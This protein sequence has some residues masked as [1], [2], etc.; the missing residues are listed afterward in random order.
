ML[1]YIIIKVLGNVEFRKMQILIVDDTVENLKLLNE[2]LDA[3]DV[4]FSRS[5]EE[6]LSLLEKEEYDLIL[7][8]IMMPGIDGYT[9]CQRL[10]NFPHHAETPVIFLTAK[11]DNESILKAFSS[12]GQDYIVKPFNT[13][14]LQ[15]RVK[16]QLLYKKY[17]N[18]LK[19][20]ITIEQEKN[21][22]K[23]LSLL[24]QSK[25]V[26]MGE[27]FSM[28]AHQWRQPLST[29]MA[30]SNGILTQIELAQITPEDLKKDLNNITQSV[31][32]LN[33]TINEYK[34]FFKPKHSFE[35]TNANEIV[36]KVLLLNK[37][38]LQDNNIKLNVHMA[39]KNF[40]F[41]TLDNELIQVF[42]VIIQNSIDA[43]ISKKLTGDI[44]LDISHTD[45]HLNITFTDHAG[46]V[47]EVDLP[48]IFELNFTNK[49]DDGMGVGLYM[50]K[51][52]IIDHLNGTI[53][54]SNTQ[55]GVKFSIT[56][57]L[58][59]TSQKNPLL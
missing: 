25:M 48:K 37:H 21:R 34:S 43:Y 26:Q 41:N 52:I 55:Q 35:Q 3:H 54:A 4:S 13:L 22:A 20:K 38:A 5:G 17:Q 49:G 23:D 7:L 50:V 15:A 12:G 31:E 30:I 32:H 16:N 39:D 19:N 14:E 11:S 18:E 27:S 45:E 57:P 51:K 40:I 10:R 33:R 58:D 53:N 42:L 56:L 47:D 2:V 59:I 44:D 36:N 28:M 8:D 6:A 46:G 24:Q 1:S 29:I 9:T